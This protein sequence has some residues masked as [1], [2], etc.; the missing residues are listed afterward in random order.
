MSKGQRYKS[1]LD[2][3]YYHARPIPPSVMD[4]TSDIVNAMKKI[5]P[6]RVTEALASTET[7][8]FAIPPQLRD[9]I[10]HAAREW[11]LTPVD[12][13]L[14]LHDLAQNARVVGLREGWIRASRA[15]VTPYKTFAEDQEEAGDD[16]PGPADATERMGQPPAKGLGGA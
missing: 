1:P 4:A 5:P 8:E 10:L 16:D 13:F 12:Y 2:A 3:G 11:G 6:I 7:I 9:E 14:R 15:R